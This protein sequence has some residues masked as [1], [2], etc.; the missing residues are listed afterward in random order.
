MKVIVTGATG[1]VGKGVLLECLQNEHISEVLV[2]GR[3]SVNIIDSKLTEIIHTDMLDLSPISEKLKGYDACFFCVGVSAFRMG[4]DVYTKITHDMPIYVASVLKKLNPEI[5]FHHVSA[6]GADN[7]EQS[8][9]MWEQVKGK[10]ENSLKALGLKDLYIYRPA[11]IKPDSRTPSSTPIY[12][13]FLPIFSVLHP[14]IVRMFP[15]FSTTAFDIGR[16]MV[17]NTLH[18]SSTKVLES[19]AINKTSGLL[20]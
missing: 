4:E 3:K 12:N 6:T 10:S 5:I 1:M 19:E 2:V 17:Q 13:I 9:V 14:L 16:A 20:S 11:Y 7:T 18:A 15:K 8:K